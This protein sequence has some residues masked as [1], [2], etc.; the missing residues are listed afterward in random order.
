M[1]PE[2]L[3]TVQD[4]ITLQTARHI[5]GPHKQVGVAA[6]ECVELAKE[7]IKALRY[8]NF[9]D[10]VKHTKSQVTEEVADVLIVLD[11]V[12]NLYEI[13]DSQLQPY[14]QKKMQRLEYWLNNSNSI[15]FTTNHR[16]LEEKSY[17]EYQKDLYE[18]YKRMEESTDGTAERKD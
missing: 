8:D 7:L 2:K 13:T 14:I 11:H 10:A 16:D 3:F 9:D 1:N 17:T 4:A 6:E 12:I 5:Y 15:E 18:Q